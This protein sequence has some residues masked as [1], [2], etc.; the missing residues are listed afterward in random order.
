MEAVAE[1][2]NRCI[3]KK[4]ISSRCWK[5]TVWGKCSKTV[6]PRHSSLPAGLGMV[7][8]TRY[9]RHVSLPSFWWMCVFK[10]GP[11]FQCSST[12]SHSFRCGLSLAL[13]KLRS[14]LNCTCHRFLLMA[15]EWAM[16]FTYRI[17]VAGLCTG[18]GSFSLELLCHPLLHSASASVQ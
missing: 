4:T 13:V 1:T 18:L 10:H 9:K 5:A 6:G 8:I 14:R 12:R 17:A 15:V 7:L 11:N 2:S 3:N 16:R